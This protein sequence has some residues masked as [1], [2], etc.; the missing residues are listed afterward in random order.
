[1]ASLMTSLFFIYDFVI[2]VKKLLELIVSY[3]AGLN[4]F[5]V[6]PQ[7]IGFLN[8]I[9]LECLANGGLDFLKRLDVILCDEGNCKP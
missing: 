3:L 9:F 6:I 1:M 2:F 7:H 8:F 5:F 4:D